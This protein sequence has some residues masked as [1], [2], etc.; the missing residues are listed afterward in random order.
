MSTNTELIVAPK[1]R[2]QPTQAKPT[3]VNDGSVSAPP[4]NI[5]ARVVPSRL[6]PESKSID[7]HPVILV[8]PET[9]RRFKE[10]RISDGYIHRINAP[11]AKLLDNIKHI[12]AP[13][14]ATS[15]A[16]DLTLRNLRGNEK[17]PTDRTDQMEDKPSGVAIRPLAGLPLTGVIVLGL[18]QISDWDQVRYDEF[19]MC[20]IGLLKPFSVCRRYRPSEKPW[21]KSKPLDKRSSSYHSS[22]SYPCTN[23]HRF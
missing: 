1:T 17:A 15:P 5:T 8:P 12:T 9:F 10:Q 16:T 3:E 4:L 14:V 23:P 19:D 13:S 18:P 21:T 22:C 6:F 11:I 7:I 2:K 20:S